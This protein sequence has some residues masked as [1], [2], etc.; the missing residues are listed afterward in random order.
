MRSHELKDSELA[1]FLRTQDI[2]SGWKFAQRAYQLHRLQHVE[3]E[4]KEI[5]HRAQATQQK[6]KERLAKSK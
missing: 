6:L 1:E 3:D 5:A 4:I 2:Y